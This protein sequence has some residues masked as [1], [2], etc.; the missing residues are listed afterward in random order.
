MKK[1]MLKFGVGMVSASV[2]LMVLIGMVLFSGTVPQAQAAALTAE[3]DTPEIGG[4]SFDF[5]QGSNVIYAGAIVVIN[6]A[7]TAEAGTDAASKRVVGRCERTQDNTG[8]NYKAARTIRVKTGVFR[9][10]NGGSFTDANIGDLAYISD[11]QTVTTGASASQDIIAGTIVDVDSDGVW[12]NTYRIGANGAAS[13]TTLAASGAATLGSTLSVAGATT[14]AALTTSGTTTLGGTTVAITN[15]ATVAGT[16]VG[17][18]TIAA[19]GFKIGSVSG[20]S[21]IATNKGTGYTN[22]WCFSGGVL[23]NVTFT[24]NMP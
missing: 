21:G 14:A 23:T 4:E 6:S 17:S 8:V 15:N 10:V 3:R 12:V 16:L 1:Q 22:L 24:G 2:A 20:Y 7:G 18:S 13:V 19:S 5:T 11:D 9:W